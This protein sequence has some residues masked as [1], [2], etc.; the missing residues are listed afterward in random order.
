MRSRLLALPIC[1]FVLAALD[2]LAARGEQWHRPLDFELPL[3]S[4]LLWLGFGALALVPASLTAPFIGRIRRSENEHGWVRESLGLFGWMVAPVALHATLDRHTGIY[5]DLSALAG[6][7][8]W[9]EAVLVALAIVLVLWLAAKLFTR[10]KG[11]VVAATIL[12]VSFVALVFFPLRD[13]R[14]GTAR[15]AHADAPNLLLLIWDTTRAPSLADYGYDRE[16]TPHLAEFAQQSVL[17]EEARSV[18]VY[19]LTSHVTMLTG[20][21][22]SQ[23]GSRLARMQY[24]PRKTPSI[25]RLLREGGYRTGAFVGTGVL[26]AKSGIVDG[27]EVYDDQVDPPVCDTGAWSLVHDVQS[28]LAR[29][30]PQTFNRHGDPHG[31]QDF[32]R[33]ADEVPRESSRM[34]RVRR[35][36]AVVLHGQSL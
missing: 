25:S 11:G 36:A 15:S 22:P 13:E 8:P 34:D 19:T 6:P 1:A 18:A 31:I 33:P 28:I 21:Y 24:S 12:A 4:F 26:Q 5:A 3:Q 14:F 32:Q 2:T 9:F 16:T 29:I 20:A 23:H 27:F 35:L 30:W 10:L 17:F 7:R